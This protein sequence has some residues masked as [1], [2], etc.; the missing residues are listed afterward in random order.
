[1]RIGAFLLLLPLHNPVRIAEDTATLDILS[2][3]RFELDPL[4]ARAADV[5]V[6]SERAVF[7]EAVAGA[8]AADEADQVDGVAAEHG[9]RALRLGR[10]QLRLLGAFRQDRRL[11]RREAS[12]RNRI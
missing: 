6:G 9:E 5:V 2:E 8:E 4:P 7:A 10:R 3:G 11:C 12:F 1:M